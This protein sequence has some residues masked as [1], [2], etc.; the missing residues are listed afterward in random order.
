MAAVEEGGGEGAFVVERRPLVEARLFTCMQG[1][2]PFSETNFQDFSRTQIYFSRTEIHINPFTP[3]I[4][5]LILCNVR[6]TFQYF[7]SPGK[8]YNKIPG[9]SRF[10]TARTNPLY[11]VIADVRP[12]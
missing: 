6:H 4:S 12:T 1:S 7:S 2:C 11:V 9:L 3:K 10:F 8:F 5:I